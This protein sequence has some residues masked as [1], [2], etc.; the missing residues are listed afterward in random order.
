VAVADAMRHC[1]G[2]SPDMLARYGGEEFVI[3][4]P[5]VAAQ[6]AKTVAQRILHEVRLLAIPHRMSTVGEFVT[7]SI[8]AATVAPGDGGNPEALIR[9]ADRLL[10]Q[11][12]E[13]GRDRYCAA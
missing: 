13:T 11:A 1:A 3:L 6:G 10:Y 12:K 8:G 2:R 9:A 5:N 4:L 7:V